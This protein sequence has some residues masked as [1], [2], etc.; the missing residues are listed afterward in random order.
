MPRKRKAICD[1]QDDIFG[2]ILADPALMNFNGLFDTEISEYEKNIQVNVQ[3][4]REFLLNLQMDWREVKI[5]LLILRVICPLISSNNKHFRL[6][7]QFEWKS[8]E[9]LLL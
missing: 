7:F 1:E 9:I 8:L 4:N 5:S 3:K 2:D 6:S